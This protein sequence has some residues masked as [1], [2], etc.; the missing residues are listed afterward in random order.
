MVGIGSSYRLLPGQFGAAIGV[1]RAGWSIFGIRPRSRTVEY[2]VG[3][4]LNDWRLD[5]G[6]RGRDFTGSFRIEPKGKLLMLFGSVNVGV[7]GRVDHHVR[8]HFQDCVFRRSGNGQVEPGTAN[9]G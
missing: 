5:G 4:K 1:E 3:R 7:G 6:S 2:I 8:T 9:C